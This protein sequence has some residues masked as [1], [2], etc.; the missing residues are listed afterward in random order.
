M[1][2]A[3]VAHAPHQFVAA[4]PK[5]KNQR[6]L[7]R[8]LLDAIVESRRLAAEREIELLLRDRAGKFTDDTEREI[9]QI[10]FSRTR[11]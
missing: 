2:Y 10:L 6:S 4:S 8:R 11:W 5:A 3:R 9:E 1:A 7:W